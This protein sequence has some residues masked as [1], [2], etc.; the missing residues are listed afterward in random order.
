MASKLLLTPLE[1]RLQIYQPLLPNQLHVRLQASDLLLSRCLGSD[2]YGEDGGAQSLDVN[3][4][5]TLLAH[6]SLDYC[7]DALVRVWA[8][9]LGSAWGPHWR[10]EEKAETLRAS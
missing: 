8:P 1:I 6:P 2:R 10:C 3:G 9:R 7:D 4:P 5:D